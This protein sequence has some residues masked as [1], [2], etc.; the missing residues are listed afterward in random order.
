MPL[1]WRAACPSCGRRVPRSGILAETT[2]CA[3]CSAS[4]RQNEAWNKAFYTLFALVAA[5]G[6]LALALALRNAASTALTIVAVVA[7]LLVLVPL[8]ALVWPYCTKYELIADPPKPQGA[9]APR[10]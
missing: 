8:S 3:G 1:P 9:D 4:L 6:G 5:G 2:R 10:S 7:F